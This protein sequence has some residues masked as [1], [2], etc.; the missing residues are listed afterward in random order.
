[1]DLKE[2]AD[3]LRPYIS[4]GK[5]DAD[6]ISEIFSNFL[7]NAALNGC[8]FFQLQPKTLA[9]YLQDRPL[10]KKHAQFF[11]EHRDLNKFDNWVENQIN[12][13]D[14]FSNVTDWLKEKGSPGT[15]PSLEIG[16]LLE[17]IVEDLC[18]KSDSRKQTKKAPSPYEG[19]L[20][21][22]KKLQSIISET[23]PAPEK[24]PIPELENDV[25][26]PYLKELLSAYGEAEQN[27]QFGIEELGD[28][29][30]YEEDLS[31]RRIDYY[32][33]ASVERGVMELELPDKENQFDV[34]KREI[35]EGVKDTVKLPCS[36]GFVRMLSV[37][38]HVVSLP[39]TAYI[40]YPSSSW[41]NS[42]I[43]RGVCH[44]LVNEKKI[45]WVK[46]HG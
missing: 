41:L 26:Q 20:E 7:D 34:L 30:E 29:P 28:Y 3:G 42:Q 24:I 15:Y 27:A 16:E 18:K 1:M 37:M 6:Y 12:G 14:S 35:Y 38:H 13:S 21:T 39:I 8:S 2:F 11:Y 43:R 17:S 32:S 5:S 36:N 4:E 9:K 23:L 44:Y 40:L 25:E 22:I 31:E 46:K 10:P 33:A 45:R 19:S